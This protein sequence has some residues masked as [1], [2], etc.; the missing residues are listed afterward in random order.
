MIKGILF[1][2]DGTLIDS[3][4]SILRCFDVVFEKMFP[5]VILTE[6]DRLSFLGPT[7]VYTF[8]QYTDDEEVIEKAIEIYISQSVKEHDN[9][10]IKA[11]PNAV[12]LLKSLKDSGLKTGVVTSKRNKMARYG[13]EI[14]HLLDYVDVVIGSD[15]VKNHK[16][17]PESLLKACQYLN[18]EP[19][20]VM[21]VGDHENDIL[22]AKAGNMISVGVTYSLNV[23]NLISSK[24]SYLVDD[25]IDILKLI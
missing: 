14:N 13:L 17:N 16:P 7:L 22:A 19:H 9:H 4:P 24:P 11:F 8:S 3:A 18:L 21:Y 1:D 20:E 15:D 25:L 10:N 5:K 12:E 6:E 2:L 23:S